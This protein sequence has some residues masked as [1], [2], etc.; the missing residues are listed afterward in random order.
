MSA[1]AAASKAQAY[2]KAFTLKGRARQRSPSTV[3]AVFVCVMGCRCETGRPAHVRR[4]VAGGAVRALGEDAEDLRAVAEREEP[5]LP[6]RLGD[7]QTAGTRKYAKK[8]SYKSID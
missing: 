3:R 4:D 2:I 5:H 7:Q 6:G 8:H 1:A